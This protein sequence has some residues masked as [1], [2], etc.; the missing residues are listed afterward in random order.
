MHAENFGVYGAR[1][2]HAQL[3]R[4]PFARVMPRSPAARISRSTVHRATG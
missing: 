4:G 2:I 3:V 1:K